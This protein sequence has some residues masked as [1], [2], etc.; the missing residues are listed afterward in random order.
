M[1]RNFISFLDWSEEELMHIVEA[2]ES[3]RREMGRRGTL[4]R[5]LEESASL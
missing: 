3:F 5:C 1:Q 2:A 4:L